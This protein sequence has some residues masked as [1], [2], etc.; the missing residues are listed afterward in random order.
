MGGIRQRLIKSRLRCCRS[1]EQVLSA[2]LPE[3]HDPLFIAFLFLAV[4]DD[5]RPPAS[6]APAPTCS[7]AGDKCT[8]TDKCT[9]SDE[10]VTTSRAS[11]LLG[12]QRSTAASVS[13]A[14]INAPSGHSS[15]RSLG[16]GCRAVS[17]PPA[18][19]CLKRGW[20]G[21]SLLFCTVFRRVGWERPGRE[22][23][24]G[25]REAGSAAEAMFSTDVEC[26]S[27]KGN[28]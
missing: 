8:H 10:Q 9:D 14:N 11:L 12:Q 4:L 28:A 18:P 27:V 1:V 26:V 6:D 5:I 20:V 21:A 22:Y 3:A 2:A 7:G 23:G 19:L 15:R 16:R 17:L 24:R 25:L 13:H